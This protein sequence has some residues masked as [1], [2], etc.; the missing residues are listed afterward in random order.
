MKKLLSL[1]M[2]LSVSFIGASAFAGMEVCDAEDV[3][4]SYT[5]F[6]YPNG[7]Q[8]KYIRITNARVNISSV[9]CM[10]PHMAFILD[11][12]SIATILQFLGSEVTNVYDQCLNL[13]C[14]QSIPA[15]VDHFTIERIGPSFSTRPH[16]FAIQV[17]SAYG[18]NCR[19]FS[20]DYMQLKQDS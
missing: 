20:G 3:H 12:D 8:G 13:S 6:T 2:L 19:V 10:N 11:Q 15:G 14:T 18:E 9:E 5:Q 16:Y 4:C 17:D 1:I 7:L